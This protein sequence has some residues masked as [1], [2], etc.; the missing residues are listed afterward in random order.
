MKTV[1]VVLTA[2]VTAL[3]LAV[4]ADIAAAQEIEAVYGRQVSF[5]RGELFWFVEGINQAELGYDDG[6]AE[7]GQFV[8]EVPD[9]PM[10]AVRFD[11]L[12][13]PFFLKSAKVFV[14]D[15]DCFPDQP[16]DQF[17]PFY[18]SVHED[19]SGLPGRLIS[20]GDVA[21]NPLEWECGGVWV[22]MDVNKLTVED[23]VF[24]A[25]M[26]WQ[27][28]FPANPHFG[29]DLST[30]SQHS[31]YSKSDESGQPVWHQC[32]WGQYMIRS[33]IFCNDLDGNLTI[34]PG[35]VL[36][37]SFRIYS[38]GQPVV[39]PGEEFYDTTVINHMH[40]RVKL[41]SPQNYF[42]VTSFNNGVESESSKVVLIEGSTMKRADVRFE[43]DLFQIQMRPES[44]TCLQLILTNKNDR[45]INYRFAGA[46]IIAEKIFAPVTIGIVP[47]EG[48]IPDD[49]ADTVKLNL[50]TN[51]GVLGDYSIEI[52]IELWD[53]VQGYMDEIYLIALEVGEFTHAEDDANIVPGEFYLGQNYPNP[54]N[55]STIIP[56]EIT[57]DGL[58]I[59]LQIINIKG[60]LVREFDL[61]N[62]R[63]GRILWN[64]CDKSGNKMPSGIYLL[65]AKSGDIIQIRKILLLK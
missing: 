17:T 62:S 46:D 56:Y 28:E 14:A 65:R 6:S 3:M 55:N 15:A 7:L 25:A 47:S 63:S 51:S 23:T 32:N 53:S 26:Q 50:H 43:P 44:D 1:A 58:N 48:D 21:V 31:Y 35:A 13:P 42:C 24:W 34:A 40:C 64:A 20:Q 22:E 60:E 57:Q 52:S 12:T 36:P 37:D 29:L 33:E 49:L 41:P 54:F 39:Y 16:G 38:S 59:T 4:L 18:I 9:D 11:S 19:S 2:L 61:E 5:Y 45:R 10:A 27:E 30:T 8:S